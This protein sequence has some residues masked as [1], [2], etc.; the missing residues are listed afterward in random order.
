MEKKNS[1]HPKRNGKQ[2]GRL[3]TM[4]RSGRSSTTKLQALL[5]EVVSEPLHNHVAL[6]WGHGLIV[7]AEDHSLVGLLNSDSTRPLSKNTGLIYE[8]R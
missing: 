7:K 4:K 3:S 2:Q 5:N 1:D 6:P 8:V